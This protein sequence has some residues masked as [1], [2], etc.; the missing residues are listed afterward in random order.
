MWD[1]ILQKIREGVNQYAEIRVQ[2]DEPPTGAQVMPLA[3]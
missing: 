2:R 1:E 3:Q